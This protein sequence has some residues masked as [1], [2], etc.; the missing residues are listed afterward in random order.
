MFLAFS[1]TDTDNNNNNFYGEMRN[2]ISRRKNVYM[3]LS[4]YESY[5]FYKKWSE[6]FQK[7]NQI[8]F[9]IRTNIWLF[10]KFMANETYF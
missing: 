6:Y 9:Q 3:F 10:Y 2:V 4:F 5:N 8:I 1:Y 7:K